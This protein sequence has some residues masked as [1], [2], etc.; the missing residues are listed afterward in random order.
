[1]RVLMH[2]IVLLLLLLLLLLLYVHIM[3]RDSHVTQVFLAELIETARCVQVRAL[4]IG[5]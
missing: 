1:M 3:S 4:V 5:I 2:L